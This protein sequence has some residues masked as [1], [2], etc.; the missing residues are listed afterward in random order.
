MTQAIRLCKRWPK[1]SSCASDD[2][3]RPI[4]L[5][6]V[7]P[8]RL[9]HVSLTYHQT[10]INR[11]LPKAFEDTKLSRAQAAPKKHSEVLKLCWNQALKPPR[12][13]RTSTFEYDEHSKLNHPNHPPRSQRSLE[14]SSK[15]S[16]NLIN[17]KSVK[18]Y[19]FKPPK[20]RR[21]FTTN[22]QIR[23]T[24]EEESSE[25]SKSSS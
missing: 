1:Q 9:R 5:W 11:S 23:R 19:G 16:R 6:H 10:P 20:P 21:T 12:T 13:S 22:L 18:L 2:I 15:A 8:I 4:K 25:S 17:Y 3:S 7:S 14:S 24:F